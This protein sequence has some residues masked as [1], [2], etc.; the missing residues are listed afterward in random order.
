MAEQL[1][2]QKRQTQHWQEWLSRSWPRSRKIAARQREI[3]QATAATHQQETEQ[4]RRQIAE[5]TTHQ[6]ELQAADE[7]DVATANLLADQRRQT[8]RW[9]EIARQKSVEVEGL[10]ARQRDSEQTAAANHRQEADQLRR[11]IAELTA[12]RASCKPA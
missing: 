2:D 10:A 12:Q 11:Q 7:L 9:Q 3:E 6:S 8:Q 1:A 4:L 5:L